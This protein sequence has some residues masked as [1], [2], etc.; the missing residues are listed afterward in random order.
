VACTG[1]LSGCRA[2][3]KLPAMLSA[4]MGCGALIAC[5]AMMQTNEATAMDT[6]AEMKDIGDEMRAEAG[7]PPASA[8]ASTPADRQDGKDVEL[9]RNAAV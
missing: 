5:T 8:K 6:E 2:P 1:R 4:V 7:L 3:C 9:V